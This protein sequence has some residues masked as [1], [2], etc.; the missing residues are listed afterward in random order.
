MNNIIDKEDVSREICQ[1][2]K[3]NKHVLPM[4]ILYWDINISKILTIDNSKMVLQKHN[5]YGLFTSRFY[6]SSSRC[7]K[8]K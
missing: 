1:W 2:I 7:I 4:N 3:D 6:K 8:L 5:H